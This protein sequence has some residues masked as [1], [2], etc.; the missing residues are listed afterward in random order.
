MQ[1][2]CRPP[3]TEQQIPC[4]VGPVLLHS[5]LDSHPFCI[6]SCFVLIIV[7]SLAIT[8]W[9][10]HSLK[11][12]I[13]MS[14]PFSFLR[15][16]LYF[17]EVL[18]AFGISVTSLSSYFL[19]LD[20]PIIQMHVIDSSLYLNPASFAQRKWRKE[21]GPVVYFRNYYWITHFL[22]TEKKV[23]LYSSICY[24]HTI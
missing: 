5:E 17:L 20:M 21:R 6:P 14:L 22:H 12:S 9:T 18:F 19:T 8:H 13:L 3:V 23:S 4:T 7:L 1:T 11:Q 24:T 16:Q 2:S 10:G 15:P